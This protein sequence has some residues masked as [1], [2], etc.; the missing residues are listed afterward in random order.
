MVGFSERG[1]SSHELQWEGKVDSRKLHQV[2]GVYISEYDC[3]DNRKHLQ[4]FSIL[5]TAGGSQKAFPQVG[6]FLHADRDVLTLEQ[7]SE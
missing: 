4:V 7:Y 5:K 1:R 6:G 2:G 3:K